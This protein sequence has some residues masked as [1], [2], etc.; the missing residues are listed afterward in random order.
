MATHLI[1]IYQY[2]V[3]TTNLRHLNLRSNHLSAVDF[4]DAADAPQMN[5][6]NTL[7]LTDNKLNDL[8]SFEKSPNLRLLSLMQN[9]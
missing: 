2:F 1:T 4:L 7:D 8:P 9:R 6:L 3:G 5:V